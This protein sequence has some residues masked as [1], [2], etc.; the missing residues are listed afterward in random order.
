MPITSPKSGNR[1]LD[2]VLSTILPADF[3][4][5][6]KPFS[7]D[8]SVPLYKGK[9]QMCIEPVTLTP[10]T[11]TL[12]KEQISFIQ[13]H[14]MVSIS[15]GTSKDILLALAKEVVDII[16]NFKIILHLNDDFTRNESIVWGMDIF[17]FLPNVQHIN[18]LCFRYE[19]LKHIEGLAY[20]HNLQSFSIDGNLKSKMDFSVL[21][22]FRKLL[23]L[24]INGTILN[25]KYYD[26]IN[27]NNL[28]RLSLRKIHLSYLTP[29]FDLSELEIIHDLVDAEKMGILFPNIRHLSIAN[30]KK[31]K[32]FNFISSLH[33]LEQL[34][35]NTVSGLAVLPEILADSLHT[36]QLVNCKN[37]YDIHSIYSLQNLKRLAL[38]YSKVNPEELDKILSQL[39]LENFYFESDKHKI[40][41]QF[42]KLAAK[43]QVESHMLY[44]QRN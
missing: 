15:C 12:S 19:E 10:N 37:L 28:N 43:Y 35:I 16:D 32:D 21:R 18:I 30:C 39:T 5:S 11:K 13:H 33:H 1:Y 29:Q 8:K 31:L 20:I 7:V 6:E 25:E 2:A 44:N 9:M 42:R 38:T 17:E 34:Y 14:R 27:Q 40:N 4:Q 23:N 22:K 36:L 41:E 24:S 3:F 26:I